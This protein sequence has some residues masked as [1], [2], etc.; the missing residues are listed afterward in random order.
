MM[1]MKVDAG[2]P[3]LAWPSV[4]GREPIPEYQLTVL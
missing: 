3:F 2:D 4:R 1:A